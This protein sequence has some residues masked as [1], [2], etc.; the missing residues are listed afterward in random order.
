MKNINNITQN[1]YEAI[2]LFVVY[3]CYQDRKLSDQ[4]LSE[5]FLQS[6]VM[7]NFYFECYGEICDLDIEEVTFSLKNFIEI[8]E[9]YFGKKTSNEEVKFFNN[10]ITDN[11][12]R[13]FALLISKLAASK[14]GLHKLE[15]NKWN[16]WFK[17]WLN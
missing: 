4:E 13:D 1:S 3:I 17:H 16:F 10:I 12:L 11:K 7:K 14:D 5:L 6:D 9:N 15:E 2:A 8:K